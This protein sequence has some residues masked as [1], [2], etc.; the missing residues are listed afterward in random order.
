M[1]EIGSFIDSRWA[2]SFISEIELL[3]KKEITSKEDAI[4]RR[5]LST[6]AKFGHNQ[7]VSEVT[8]KLREKYSIKIPD[9]I[10]AATAIN[11][12]IPLLTADRDFAKIKELDSVILVL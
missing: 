2:Y 8:I 10:I 5:M 1:P 11:L 6:C 9:A 12:G 4:V 3:S 7:A